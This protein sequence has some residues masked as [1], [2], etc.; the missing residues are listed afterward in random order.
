MAVK[1]TNLIPRAA[2]TFWEAPGLKGK[3]LCNKLQHI[4]I[5]ENA[6]L[7]AEDQSYQKELNTI[8]SKYRAQTI[9]SISTLFLSAIN[10]IYAVFYNKTET[11]AFK[12]MTLLNSSGLAI[13]VGFTFYSF[14]AKSREQGSEAL[15]ISKSRFRRLEVNFKEV[16]FALNQC[17]SQTETDQLQVALTFLE[18]NNKKY[19]QQFE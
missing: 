6:C 7:M 1:S 9:L 11:R 15:E 5:H 4:Y 10:L 19:A 3:L 12:I 14:Y 16:A 18:Q 2:M 13:G 17:T 8:N